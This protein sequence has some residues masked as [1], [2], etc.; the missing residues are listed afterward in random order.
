VLA[1]ED[2]GVFGLVNARCQVFD[3]DRDDHRGD[4]DR[5]PAS[6]RLERPKA[7]LAVVEVEVE[8]EEL[9]PYADGAGLKVDA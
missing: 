6:L 5:P 8:V 9:F 3:E 7:H 2:E 4:A 1:K